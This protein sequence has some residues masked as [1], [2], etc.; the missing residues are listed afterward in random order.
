MLRYLFGESKR[1]SD[2]LLDPCFTLI[3]RFCERL[4]ERNAVRGLHPR[5]HSLDLFAQGLRRSLDELEQSVYCAFRYSGELRAE[6]PARL[7]NEQAD[8]YFRYL[9]FYKNAMIRV[10]ANLDKL[11]YFMNDWFQLHTERVKPKFSY[12]TVL[13]RMRQTRTHAKLES[14]LYRIKV[15]YGPPMQRLR[16]KRNLEI[17]LVNVE[18][19]DPLKLLESGESGPRRG[20]SAMNDLADLRAGYEMACRSMY[21]VFRYVGNSG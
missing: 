19:L 7:G 4:R 10:F 17:H 6:D 16:L 8:D 3:D 13:R 1:G 5:A 18:L 14:R 2:E 12:F 20:E 21:E 11:G 15:E 9:Y